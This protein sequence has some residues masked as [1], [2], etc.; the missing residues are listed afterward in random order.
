MKNELL[1]NYY[2]N[3]KSPS[4][5]NTITLKDWIDM[6][7]SSDYSQHIN[8]LR[9]FDLSKKEWD[10]EKPTFPAIT[11][12]FLYNKYK[13]DSN[14]IKSTGYMY[15]DIDNDEFDI[16]SIQDKVTAYWKSIR[17]KGW[18][19]V[20]KVDGITYNNFKFN[21]TNICNELGL[22]DYIDINAVKHSQFNIL[23]FDVNAYYN[24]YGFVFNCIDLID[25]PTPYLTTEE[26]DI[27]VGGRDK[28]SN[29]R[30]D[31]TDTIPIP[32]N[33][34]YV[35]NWNEGYTIIK[36]FLIPSKLDDNRYNTLLSF[37][38]NLVY[39][40]PTHSKERIWKFI[41]GSSYIISKDGIDDKRITSIVNSIFRQKEQGKLTPIHYN[42]VRR[43]IFRKG[44][45]WTKEEYS[46][47]IGEEM[48]NMYKI[49]SS[50][51]LQD[52]INDWDFNNGLINHRS[53]VKFGKMSKTTVQKY[54]S[55]YKQQINEM[56]KNYTEMNTQQHTCEV[57]TDARMEDNTKLIECITTGNIVDRIRYKI[58]RRI[59]N[60]ID[61]R[62][63]KKYKNFNNKMSFA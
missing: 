23:S 21:Y 15:I 29:T 18:G 1:I 4:V 24:E 44:L 42:K 55:Q 22:L 56:N 34:D 49:K 58:P 16:L 52:I 30:F 45:K 2:T 50:N 54:Y 31:N 28:F 63:E 20:V 6:I 26:E 27:Y 5:V 38:N 57:I 12:N 3:I 7:K 17:G 47:V 19:V 10:N 60:Q 62:Y 9:L 11:I 43:I 48:K 40:N 14:I 61:I 59:F 32:S 39:L 13:K 36:C 51:K 25:V 41:K 8:T 53:I 33:K 37:C 35:S 46:I